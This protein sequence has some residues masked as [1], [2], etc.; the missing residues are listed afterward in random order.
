[1]SEELINTRM[2]DRT[3][4]DY[5]QERWSLVLTPESKE[6]FVIVSADHKWFQQP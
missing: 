5:S 2:E 6:S 3:A 1:M 4:N